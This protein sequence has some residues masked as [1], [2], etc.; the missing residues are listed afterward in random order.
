[1]ETTVFREKLRIKRNPWAIDPEDEGEFLNRV[2]ARL[3]D[4]SNMEDKNAID[5]ELDDILEEMV[6]RYSD[7]IA[8]TCE[9]ALPFGKTI[10]D[11]RLARLLNASRVR[12]IGS[13]SVANILC[14]IKSILLAKLKN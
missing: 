3:L 1:M 14:R 9:I 12:G 5:E 6:I 10:S 7:E 8:E 13:V 2:K 4:I 11:I